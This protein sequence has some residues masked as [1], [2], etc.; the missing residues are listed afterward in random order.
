MIRQAPTTRGHAGMCSHVRRRKDKVYLEI[1]FP[2]GDLVYTQHVA[3][4]I[5]FVASQNEMVPVR[6]TAFSG[7][8]TTHACVDEHGPVLFC[9]VATTGS[10]DISARAGRGRA[11]YCS[12]YVTSLDALMIITRNQCLSHQAIM[13]D[14][15]R[16]DT[17]N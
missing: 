1:H 10:S 2:D 11:D 9:P 15:S 5:P 8:G 17:L 4:A 6:S 12:A 16:D 14:A 3:T 7:S 13:M